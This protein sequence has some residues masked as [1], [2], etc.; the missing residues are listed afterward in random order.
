MVLVGHEHE[1]ALEK[2]REM[3]TSDIIDTLDGQ[4]LLPP[5]D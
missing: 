5:F 3:S 1:Q 4:N 2:F